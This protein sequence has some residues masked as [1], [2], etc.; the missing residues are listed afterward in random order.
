MFDEIIFDARALVEEKKKSDARTEKLKKMFEVISKNDELEQSIRVL[1]C[2]DAQ[3]IEQVIADVKKYERYLERNIEREALKDF[4]CIFT[5]MCYKSIL[6]AKRKDQKGHITVGKHGFGIREYEMSKRLTDLEELGEIYAARAQILMRLNEE[7]KY[8]WV[9]KLE[10]FFEIVP[11]VPK[12]AGIQIELDEPVV[13]VTDTRAPREYTY[14]EFSADDGNEETLTVEFGGHG[15]RHTIDLPI[16][17][18]E[19]EEDNPELD[20]EDLMMYYQFQKIFRSCVE[21]FHAQVDKLVTD[22]DMV[23][24]KLYESFGRQLMLKQV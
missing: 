18:P 3:L 22:G 14:V 16:I 10:K 21:K 23:M 2:S 19:K 17:Y 13:S 15:E 5:D 6:V 20:M 1:I 11:T 7:H 24:K 8:E 4:N 12:A 9:R